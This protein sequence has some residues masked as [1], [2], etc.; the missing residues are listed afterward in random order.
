MSAQ[1]FELARVNKVQVMG[2]AD[3]DDDKVR[4]IY[5]VAPSAFQ[6]YDDDFS[7]GPG[8]LTPHEAVALGE[9]LVKLGTAVLNGELRRN[10]NFGEGE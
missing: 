9:V 10:A 4:T 7:R 3:T 2:I 6:S 5:I 8:K 1:L